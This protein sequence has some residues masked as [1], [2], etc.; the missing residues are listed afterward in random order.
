MTAKLARKMI[1]SVCPRPLT[2]A[3]SHI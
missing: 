2:L 1:R 3:D